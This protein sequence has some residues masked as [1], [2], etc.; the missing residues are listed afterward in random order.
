MILQT[1]IS[2]QTRYCVKCPY[3]EIFWSV[4][5]SIWTEYGEMHRISSNSVRMCENADKKTPN[6]NTFLTVKE[7]LISSSHAC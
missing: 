4:F 2:F 6:T 5:S 3:S 1:A 7:G